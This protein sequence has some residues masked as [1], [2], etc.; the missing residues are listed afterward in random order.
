[1]ALRPRIIARFLYLKSRCC[2][3]NT[4][5]GLITTIM[6]TY[7]SNVIKP[8]RVSTRFTYFILLM[9]LTNDI[10]HSL[11][12]RDPFPQSTSQK[13]TTPKQTQTRLS[14]RRRPRRQPERKTEP[15]RQPRRKQPRRTANPQDDHQDK[16]AKAQTDPKYNTNTRTRTNKTNKTTPKYQTK[17]GVMSPAP[18]SFTS[19]TTSTEQG[20]NEPLQ[21]K[22]EC[23]NHSR[24][25]RRNQ[26]NN[27][28]K[29][30]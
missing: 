27:Q 10:H 14:R 15:T 2:L 28:Q 25:Q 29:R 26:T 7:I 22:Q 11:P 6:L 8:Y 20:C 19:A 18:T 30:V 9:Y 1:M 12:P 21:N 13:T 5:S 23:Q 4:T 24:R 17:L 3:R 16:T